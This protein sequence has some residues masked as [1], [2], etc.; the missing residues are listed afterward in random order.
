MPTPWPQPWPLI[1]NCGVPLSAGGVKPAGRWAHGQAGEQ[2]DE[3]GRSAENRPRAR[4]QASGGSL[5]PYGTLTTAVIPVP[6]ERV[7]PAAMR[8][9]RRPCP[10]ALPRR[11]AGRA[12]RDGRRLP[13]DGHDAR[14]GRRG[15]AARRAVRRGRL[16]TAAV[17]A[18]GARGGARVRAIRTSSRSSTS[19]TRASGRTSSW[20]TSTA[21]RSR[22]DCS[23][24][25]AEAVRCAAV[26]RAGCARARLRAL[27]TA[28]STA[29]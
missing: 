25:A 15:E 17:R 26:A 8:D 10:D 23:G 22:S 1:T 9:A 2:Q 29:T 27:R 7:W 28:S 24:R 13:R 12:G 11:R 20:S 19:A 18:R 6:G 14:P 21:S 3:K 4:I 16:G 5:L